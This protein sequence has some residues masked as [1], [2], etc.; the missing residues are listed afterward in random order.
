[1]QTLQ[2]VWVCVKWIKKNISFLRVEAFVLTVD[3][4]KQK[5]A[6]HYVL[7]AR[8]R[9]ENTKRS[10]IQIKG[11]PE[12]RQTGNTEELMDYA[13]IVELDHSNTDLYVINATVRY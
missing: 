2:E 11:E 13:L 10:M 7:P 12:T 9:T 8:C 3:M 1:M 4:K 6:G 5:R